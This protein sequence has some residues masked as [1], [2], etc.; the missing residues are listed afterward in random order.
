MG[1]TRSRDF[2][3]KLPLSAESSRRHAARVTWQTPYSKFPAK[4]VQ[5]RIKR[6]FEAGDGLLV[7]VLS[8]QL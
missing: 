5:R 4:T 3:H 8:L 7:R 2:K 6:T 1:K